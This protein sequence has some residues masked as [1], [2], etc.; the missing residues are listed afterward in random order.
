[1]NLPTDTAEINRRRGQALSSTVHV[2]GSDKSVY[3]LHCNAD[4]VDLLLTHALP[5]DNVI[6]VK[7]LVGNAA[8]RVSILGARREIGALVS[9]CCDLPASNPGPVLATRL[10]QNAQVYAFVEGAGRVATCCGVIKVI[11]G[12]T[13]P[14]DVDV[15]LPGTGSFDLL[16]LPIFSDDFC[17]IGCVIARGHRP[18]SSS[19]HLARG[20]T[21]PAVNG[22][23][24]ERVSPLR[25][26]R[27]Q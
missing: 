23:K 26:Q 12:P 20:P 19:P 2:H 22:N 6:Q 7:S 24:H 16:G 11:R 14:V 4:G 8:P 3:A 9:A 10:R 1:M 21:R 15:S 5:T 27:K 18:R 25:P 17:W 13:G